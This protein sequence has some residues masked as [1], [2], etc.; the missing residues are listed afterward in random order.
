[1]IQQGQNILWQQVAAVGLLVQFYINMSPPLTLEENIMLL[2]FFSHFN[3]WLVLKVFMLHV[4][5]LIYKK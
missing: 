3:T 4:T 2:W 5:L 1:M